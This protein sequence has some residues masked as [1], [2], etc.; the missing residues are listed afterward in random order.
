[1]NR[2]SISSRNAH[3]RAHNPEG[4]SSSRMPSGVSAGTM[5]SRTVPVTRQARASSLDDDGARDLVVQALARL[6]ENHERVHQEVDRAH[7]GYQGW[8]AVHQVA[9]QEDPPE[10]GF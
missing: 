8:D 7:D 3:D 2:I 10:R 5:V 6:A 4:R 9:Q 1:M